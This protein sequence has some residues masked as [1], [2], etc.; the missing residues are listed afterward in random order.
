MATLSQEQLTFFHENGYLKLTAAEHGLVTLTQLQQWTHEVRTWP[1][2]KGKWMPYFEV[3]ADGTRQLM[4]TEKF[5]DY[6]D[7]FRDLVCGDGLG[8]ILA[9]LAGQVSLPYPMLSYFL[10]FIYTIL[11]S[12]E[13]NP[14]Q[15]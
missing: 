7:Q 14:L 12:A 9:Q 1:L 13:N 2:E 3:T 6:H 5:V 8:G 10:L 4:R 15:R 11:T